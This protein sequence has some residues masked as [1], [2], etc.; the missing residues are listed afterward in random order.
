MNFGFL[1]KDVFVYM[2]F[3]IFLTNYLSIFRMRVQLIEQRESI[4]NLKLT[5]N[6]LRTFIQTSEHLKQEIQ[7]QI[8]FKA[9]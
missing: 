3:Y 7:V 8:N 5:G 2:F 4:E 9:I 6:T 1:L